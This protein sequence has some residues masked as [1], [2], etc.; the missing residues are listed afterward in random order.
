MMRSIRGRLLVLAAVWLGAALLAAFLV[1]SNLL[2]DFVTDRFDAETRAAA[3]SLIAGL[4]VGADNRIAVATPPAD[5][6]PGTTP[7]WQRSQPVSPSP[8]GLRPRRRDFRYSRCRPLNRPE[9][10]LRLSCS[11]VHPH[12]AH[13]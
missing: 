7:D 13:V 11:H 12:A 10:S 1:I 6:P 9:V 3:D 5:A 4:E 8:P 2:D